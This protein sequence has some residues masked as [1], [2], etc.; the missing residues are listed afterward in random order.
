MTPIDYLLA[1]GV[2]LAGGYIIARLFVG[3]LRS[4]DDQAGI[5]RGDEL[6]APILHE[7]LEK[8]GAPWH[9]RK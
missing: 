8:T 1:A 6:N 5:E 4:P 7:R 3:W 9:S 2:V